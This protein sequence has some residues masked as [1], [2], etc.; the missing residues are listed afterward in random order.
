M[1]TFVMAFLKRGPNRSQDSITAANLQRLYLN[2]I[3]KLAKAGKL[4]LADPF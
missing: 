2:N 3:T 1:K 4:V